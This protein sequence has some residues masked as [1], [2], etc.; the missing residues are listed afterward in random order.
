MVNDLFIRRCEKLFT[1][2]VM[3]WC[4]RYNYVGTIIDIQIIKILLT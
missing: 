2:F 1:R 3:A 4:I